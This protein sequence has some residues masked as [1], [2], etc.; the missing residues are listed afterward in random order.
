[1]ADAA[2]GLTL[3]NL[4]AL[5]LAGPGRKSIDSRDQI[6]LEGGEHNSGKVDNYSSRP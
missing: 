1:M 2:W 6:K 3:R 4:E 5:E